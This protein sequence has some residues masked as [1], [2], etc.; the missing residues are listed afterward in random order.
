MFRQPQPTII[1]L[2]QCQCGTW[3]APEWAGQL[4]SGCRLVKEGKPLE[5]KSVIVFA[6]FDKEWVYSYV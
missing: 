3:H 5:C 1:N 4:C 6:E 2:V